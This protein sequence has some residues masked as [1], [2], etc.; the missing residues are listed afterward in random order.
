VV[1]ENGVALQA[2]ELVEEVSA[3]PRRADGEP[4]GKDFVGDE[5][6]GQKHCIG[7]E[8]I[9]LA[10]CI[11]EEKRLAVFIQ[12]DVAELRRAK[13]VKRPGKPGN[14]NVVARDFDPMPFDL[15][16]IERQTGTGARARKQKAAARDGFLGEGAKH[17]LYIWYRKSS[18]GRFPA[19]SWS[20]TP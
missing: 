5:V 11:A 10:N 6:A 15:A 20:Q 18:C 8:Q 14:K 13:A 9:D 12:V 7:V 17:C 1:T 19:I 2:L 3:L 16:G 4:L